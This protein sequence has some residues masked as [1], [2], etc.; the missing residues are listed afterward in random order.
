MNPNCDSEWGVLMSPM[1]SVAKHTVP[2]QER[3]RAKR[4]TVQDQ[5]ASAPGGNSKEDLRQY[6][7]AVSRIKDISSKPDTGRIT[8]LFKES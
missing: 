2:V 1:H 6:Q 7:Q 8:D 4:K 3:R 5:E